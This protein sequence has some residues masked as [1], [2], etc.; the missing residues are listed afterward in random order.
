MVSLEIVKLCVVIQE[1]LSRKI[2]NNLTKEYPSEE[3]GEKVTEIF[4]FQSQY[5]TLTLTLDSTID[6]LFQV[7]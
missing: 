4:K 3:L 5:K 7:L 1:R 6:G 2:M